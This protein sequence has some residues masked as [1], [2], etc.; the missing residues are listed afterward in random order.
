MVVRPLRLVGANALGAVEEVVRSAVS[1]WQRAWGLPAAELACHAARAWEDDTVRAMDWRV[2]WTESGRHA[3][4]RWDAGLCDEIRNRMFPPDQ[5]Q[6]AARAAGPAAGDIAV[7][8]MDAL[9]DA[10]RLSLVGAAAVPALLRDPDAALS[11]PMSGSVLVSARLVDA[12][13]MLML[14][15]DTVAAMLPAPAPAPKLAALDLTAALG[16]VPVRL[17]VVAGKMELGAATLLSAGVGDVIRLGV[18][19]DGTFMLEASPGQPL[20]HAY[21]GQAGSGLAVEIAGIHTK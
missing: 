4:C 10:L 19:L 3:W 21:I 12:S 6:T 18:P 5:G 7:E 16:R 9:I 11:A 15:A 14:D 1:G 2:C 8:A 13:L 17:T 20:M